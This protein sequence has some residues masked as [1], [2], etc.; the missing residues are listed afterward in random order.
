MSNYQKYKANGGTMP[1][2]VHFNWVLNKMKAGEWVSNDTYIA[3][4]K[5]KE[6]YHAQ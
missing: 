2:E 4:Q 5:A 6:E 3:Q 1:R